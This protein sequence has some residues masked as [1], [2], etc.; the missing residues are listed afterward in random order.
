MNSPVLFNTSVFP[1]LR[2]TYRSFF[3]LSLSFGL[4]N[5][6]IVAILCYS[7]SIRS[8]HE[9]SQEVRIFQG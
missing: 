1:C 3:F 7:W 5:A 6:L 2:M 8:V 4:V 9:D